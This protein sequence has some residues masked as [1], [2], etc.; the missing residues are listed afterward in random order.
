MDAGQLPVVPL[1]AAEGRGVGQL[2]PEVVQ[3]YRAWNTRCEGSR[4][5][6]FRVVWVMDQSGHGLLFARNHTIE[7]IAGGGLYASRCSGRVM[8]GRGILGGC[9]MCRGVCVQGRATQGV[10]SV[11]VGLIVN[12]LV[13]SVVLTGKEQEWLR[14]FGWRQV[15]TCTAA[16]GALGAA[17]CLGDVARRVVE[18]THAARPR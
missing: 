11:G 12:R 17:W 10:W 9:L 16:R 3:L 14:D 8:H 6:G 2:M 4:A 1:S 15:E 13:E 5:Y 7:G 18:V